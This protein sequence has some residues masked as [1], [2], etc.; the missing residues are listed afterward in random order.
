[1]ISLLGTRDSHEE[2]IR[3]KLNPKIDAMFL[4][5]PGSRTIVKRRLVEIY[6][7][8][9]LFEVYSMDPEVPDR[10]SPRPCTPGSRRSCPTSTPWW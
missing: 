10:P 5:M 3:E 4:Y 7:F 9:K 2:F 1:M 8:Q 6:P